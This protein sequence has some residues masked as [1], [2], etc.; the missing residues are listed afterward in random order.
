MPVTPIMRCPRKHR[1]GSRDVMCVGCHP[2]FRNPPC[3]IVTRAMA[4]PFHL[5][6]E[7]AAPADPPHAAR[8]MMKFLDSATRRLLVA[9]GLAMPFALVQAQDAAAGGM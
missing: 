1:R 5:R 9:S 7:S 8:K 4:R 3:S 2:D 6:F